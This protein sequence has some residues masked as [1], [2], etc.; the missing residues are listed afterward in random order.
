MFTSRA[1]LI[2]TGITYR[3]LDTWARN[4]VITPTRNGGGQGVG[5]ERYFLGPEFLQAVWTAKLVNAGFDTH[6]ASRIAHR[7]VA[8]MPHS[9]LGGW[10]IKLDD[11]IDLNLI[12]EGDFNREFERIQFDA[13]AQRLL[14]AI[15]DL[16]DDNGTEGGEA[17]RSE[18][19]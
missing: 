3:Q 13:E 1:I 17:E 5:Y 12:N 11:G 14:E 8:S 19:S 16:C 18:P 7:Y 4:G 15:D 10:R 6:T 2:M 9:K